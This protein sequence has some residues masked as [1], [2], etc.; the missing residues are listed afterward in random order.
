[1]SNQVYSTRSTRT[2]YIDSIEKPFPL[3]QS[4]TIAVF[5]DEGNLIT[6]GTV[7]SNSGDIFMIP[8]STLTTDNIDVTNLTVDVSTIDD[9]ICNTI[10]AKVTD[11]TINSDMK[12]LGGAELKADLIGQNVASATLVLNELNIVDNDWRFFQD[13]NVKKIQYSGGDF[14]G[15]DVSS[16]T[17]LW[18]TPTAPQPDM[19]LINGL[20]CIPE[21]LQLAGESEMFLER[22]TTGPDQDF[23]LNVASG[24]LLRYDTSADNW[25]FDNSGTIELRVDNGNNRVELN[26]LIFSGVNQTVINKYERFQQSLTF[27][28]PWA[29]NITVTI[30]FIVVGSF[31]FLDIPSLSALSIASSALISATSLIPTRFRPS[32]HSVL[33]LSRGSNEGDNSVIGVLIISTGGQIDI[34]FER[35]TTPWNVSLSIGN[36][37]GVVHTCITYMI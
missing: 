21:K 15:F 10:T 2:F 22:L 6:N 20:L 27:S 18:Q 3:P 33:T 4:D 1:M 31:V 24:K 34:G 8:A 28:G 9:I 37:T 23:H 13:G 19:T 5:D 11:I 29:S 12:M 26:N 35:E 32:I 14:S 16:N 7:L 30:T 25:E 36:A 17:F